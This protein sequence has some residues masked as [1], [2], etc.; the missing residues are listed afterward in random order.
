MKGLKRQCQENASQGGTKDC[1]RF[2]S[3]AKFTG[4]AEDN[5]I[6]CQRTHILQKR[7]TNIWKVGH[8]EEGAFP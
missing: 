3:T 5:G 4:G 1:L 7:R 6:D 8:A 2:A